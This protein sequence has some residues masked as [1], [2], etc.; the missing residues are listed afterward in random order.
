MTWIGGGGGA[1]R[2]TD[3][4]LSLHPGHG[5]GPQ[6]HGAQARTGPNVLVPFVPLPAANLMHPRWEKASIQSP[7][8]PRA[9]NITPGGCARRHLSVAVDSGFQ[10][11]HPTGETPLLVMLGQLHVCHS[12]GLGP[13]CAAHGPF[14]SGPK[15]VEPQLSPS[16]S[17]SC[18]KSGAALTRRSCCTPIP[19][20]CLPAALQLL[21][22]AA[23]CSG[24]MMGRVRA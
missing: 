16:H 20:L 10:P 4:C 24:A 13:I 17:K 18:G 11:Q 8:A 9:R 19:G 5:G 2:D 23:R 15:Y 7:S 22:R 3:P 12:R 21:A 1:G 14:R 6:H